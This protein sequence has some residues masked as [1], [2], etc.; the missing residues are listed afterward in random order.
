MNQIRPT[1]FRAILL[2]WGTLNLFGKLPSHC[3]KSLNALISYLDMETIKLKA[4]LNILIS[5]IIFF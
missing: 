5:H 4:Y 1:S 2:L 3:A